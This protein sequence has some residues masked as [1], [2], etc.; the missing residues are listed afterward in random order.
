MNIPS[1]APAAAPKP[2][3][4]PGDDFPAWISPM[5][6]KELRQGVQSGAFAWT[7]IGLQG[8]M[9][10]LCSVFVLNGA[11]GRDEQ[12]AFAFFFWTA[13]V[14][15]MRMTKKTRMKRTKTITKT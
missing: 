13:A 4:W 9:F 15:T 11:E 8:A 1:L 14:A 3:R 5:L 7:F 10:L 6:V 12:A 2:A